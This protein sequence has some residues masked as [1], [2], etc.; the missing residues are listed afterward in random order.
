MKLAPI[1]GNNIVGSSSLER[2]TFQESK[3]YETPVRMLSIENFQNKTDCDNLKKQFIKNMP[4]KR[5]IVRNS[6][7][8]F[9]STKASTAL[10]KGK[11]YSYVQ[12]KVHSRNV[13][14]RAQPQKLTEMNIND[15]SS[16]LD[17]HFASF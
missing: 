6:D 1:S 14:F 15:D 17:M 9:L 8:D 16:F 2:I 12:P 11:K 5:S 3:M 10:A 7:I 13:Q 4:R